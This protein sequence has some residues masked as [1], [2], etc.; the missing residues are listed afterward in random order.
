MAYDNITDRTAAGALIPEE[1]S[2]ALLEAVTGQSAVLSVFPTVRMSRKQLRMPVISALATAYFVDGDT[3]L[4]QTSDAAWGNKF[5]TAEEIAVILPV[6]DAVADDVDFDIWA[7]LQ[8]AAAEAIARA[9]DD[10][11]MFGTNKPA[12]WPTDLVAAATAA[13]HVVARGTN[14]AAQGGIAEDFNDAFSLVESDGYDVN[15]IAANRSYRGILRGARDNDGSRLPE[16]NP[17]S[18]YGVPVAY[19]AR[20]LWPT[21]GSA[22]EALVGDRTQGIVGLR[23]DL[24]YKIL[25]QAVI[26]DGDGAIVYNLAQQ[27]MKALRVTLR[28]GFQVA[29]QFRRDNEDANTR[30]P[31]AVITSP[32]GS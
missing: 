8:D 29:N 19:P 21:G 12:S 17:E 6:P 13:G 15:F 7:N 28:V 22:A 32:A 24:T 5:L 26:T 30:Y 9:I 14:S 23:S 1:V 2:A 4:K 25:D 10:A 31:F 3:G 27:D 20:G 18:V 16:V 11:V